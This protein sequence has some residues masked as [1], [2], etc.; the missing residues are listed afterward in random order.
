M[1]LIRIRSATVEGTHCTLPRVP[2]K[3]IVT[4]IL[5]LSFRRPLI[6]TG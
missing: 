3:I 5:R 2:I 4:A 1:L 6:L